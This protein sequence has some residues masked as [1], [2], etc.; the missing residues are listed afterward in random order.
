MKYI[1]AVQTTDVPAGGMKKAV[2][3][4]QEVLVVNAGGKFYAI[5]A[6][7]THMGGDLSKGNLNQE[8][9]TCPRHGAK[10]DVKTGQ[11]VGNA[12]IFFRETKVKDIRCFPVKVEGKNILVGIEPPSRNP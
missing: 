4:G 3:E 6:T 8:I 9:V 1:I 2:C 12:K 5:A 11:A 10:F 7:C